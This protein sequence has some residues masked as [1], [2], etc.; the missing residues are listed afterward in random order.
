MGLHAQNIKK[1]KKKP[2]TLEATERKVQPSLDFR[3]KLLQA[4]LP[5]QGV[6]CVWPSGQRRGECP[7]GHG[8]GEDVGVVHW[9]SRTE[10]A[11]AGIGVRACRLRGPVVPGGPAV[12]GRAHQWTKSPRGKVGA[13]ACSHCLEIVVFI[14]LCLRNASKKINFN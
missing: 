13:G 9:A 5:C 2:T 4:S 8:G 14:F 10:G 1:K 3:G 11:W 6:L 12:R 7:A